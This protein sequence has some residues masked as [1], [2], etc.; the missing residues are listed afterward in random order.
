MQCAFHISWYT[1]NPSLH[2]CNLWMWL[3]TVKCPKLK[4]P[5]T[6]NTVTKAVWRLSKQVLR[7]QVMYMC[8]YT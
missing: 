5:I 3:R 1:S 7:I 6:S 4:F 2:M 8:M